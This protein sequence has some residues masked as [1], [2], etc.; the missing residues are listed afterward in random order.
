MNQ[1]LVC[2][3]SKAGRDLG[4]HNSTPSSFCLPLS[5]ETLPE[6][7]GALVA[8][9][10][11]PAVSKTLHLGAHAYIGLQTEPQ[12]QA[13]QQDSMILTIL[14]ETVVGTI[15]GPHTQATFSP[16]TWTVNETKARHTTLNA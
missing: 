7:D 5:S 1:T 12:E 13:A 3:Q 6:C 8:D 11:N 9:C 2:S 4:T 15:N 14:G 16:Q 10:H